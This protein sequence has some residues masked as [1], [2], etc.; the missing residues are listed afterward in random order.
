M[1]DTKKF[2]EMYEEMLQL[3]ANDTLQLVLN[4]EDE[5]QKNFFVMLSDFLLR[6]HQKHAI[7]ENKGY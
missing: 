6:T 1:C 2:Y 5:D 3:N 4:A 7:Q